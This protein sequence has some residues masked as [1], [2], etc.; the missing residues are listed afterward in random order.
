MDITIAIAIANVIA[1]SIT[2]AFAIFIII[3]NTISNVIAIAIAIDELFQ[4]VFWRHCLDLSSVLSW[5]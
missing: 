2:T 5:Q 4:K 3:A 1:V